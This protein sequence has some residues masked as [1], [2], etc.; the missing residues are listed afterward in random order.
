MKKLKSL[1]M[2]QKKYIIFDLDGTLIDSIGIWNLTDYTIIK[3]FSGKE[4]SFDDI[5]N[6]R[7]DYLHNNTS[8]EIYVGYCNFLIKKYNLSIE[9]ARKLSKLRREL[10][11]EIYE[12]EI[13]F[14]SNVVKLLRKLKELDYTLVLATMSSDTQIDTYSH[15]PKLIKEANIKE[16]FDLITTKESVQLKKP[17]PEIYKNVISYF[18]TNPG[19]CLVF[20]DSYSGVLAAKRA[21]IDV[22]NIYDKYSDKDRE[23][24]NEI[25]D[26]SIMDY[27][28]IIDLL[29]KK[30]SKAKKN[31]NPYEMSIL[32]SASVI[33][34][35]MEVDRTNELARASQLFSKYKEMTLDRKKKVNKSD[36]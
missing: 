10:Y 34:R 21:G 13:E 29:N 6:D 2:A 11:E 14:K 36:D 30:H 31:L 20:E 9:D 12:N 7:D 5:Q 24:I 19:K 27:Q 32:A 3:K 28:E 16:L 26:Y 8:G 15:S 23:R 4:V 17:D 18:G 25:T 33:P 22:V 35:L 1:N